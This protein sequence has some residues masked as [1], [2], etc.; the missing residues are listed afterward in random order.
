MEVSVA[1]TVVKADTVLRINDRGL[2][3]GYMVQRIKRASLIV[4]PCQSSIFCLTWGLVAFLE[5]LVLVS[6]SVTSKPMRRH[7]KLEHSRVY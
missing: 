3:G 4:K 1:E 7:V 6:Q 2:E 5:P